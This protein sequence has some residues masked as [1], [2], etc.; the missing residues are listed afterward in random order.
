MNLVARSIGRTARGVKAIELADGD[1]VVGAVAIEKDD[2]RKIITITENGFGKRTD[3][4]EFPRHNRGGKGVICHKL[5]DKTGAL[6]G[7]AAVN[8]TDDIMLITDS[9][10]IIRTRVSEIPVYNSRSTSGVIVMRLDGD[11]KISGFATLNSDGKS[12]DEEGAEFEESIETE[13][14]EN[15]QSDTASSEDDNGN[16]EQ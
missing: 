9:G 14:A 2:D 12:D 11:T 15:G 5:A 4:T 1:R 13:A 3:P 10:T 7:I 6:V 16:E 8:D